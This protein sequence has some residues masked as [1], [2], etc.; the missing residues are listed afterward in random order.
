MVYV[1]LP[2]GQ[3]F[4]DLKAKNEDVEKRR[5]LGFWLLLL[6]FHLS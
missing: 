1:S 6:Q 5:K 2:P 4:F 3:K